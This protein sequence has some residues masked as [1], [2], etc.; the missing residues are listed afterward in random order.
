MESNKQIFIDMQ[1]NIMN[2]DIP[3]IEKNKLLKNL[4]K[5]KKQKIN[6]MITGATGCG[7][8]STINALFNM[9][10]ARVGNLDP[11]TMEIT[12][13]DLGDLFL[14]DTPGLGDGKRD[15]GFMK[16]IADKLNERNENGELLI[17]LVI[18]IMDA[19]TRDLG[20]SYKLINEVII[21]NLGTEKE[22]RIL[23]AL[24]R[25]DIAMNGRHWNYE[26]NKPDAKL[27]EF[28]EEKV[29]SIHDRIKEGTGI[30]ITPIY[31][32]AG[33]KEEGEEQRPYNLSKLFY[34]II[35]FI[36]KEKRLSF[37]G[38]INN[39]KDK[40]KDNDSSGNYNEGI[41]EEFIE[42]VSDC[43]MDG[44]DIGGN[45]GTVFGKP[46]EFLGKLAG[47]TVGAIVGTGKAILKNSWVGRFFNW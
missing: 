6:I 23:I 2:G 33:Y 41:V 1:N 13:Y 42:T 27:T 20:T 32:C 46:G 16:D 35:K 22:N 47:G 30:D 7:K 44:A 10:I 8:S 19:G 14:W 21:P 5:L 18:V 15:I 38:N 3:E 39:D 29:I 45:I 11:E 25:S 37:A 24:N 31:Y 40:W 9:E 17:D 26:E 28:L 34:Y 43:A 36:P 12:K 4:L